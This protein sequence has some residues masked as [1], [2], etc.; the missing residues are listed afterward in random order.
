MYE[1]EGEEG[2]RKGRKEKEEEKKRMEEEEQEEKSVA[3]PY[4]LYRVVTRKFSLG[5]FSIIKTTYN[6]NFFTVKITDKV[7]SLSKF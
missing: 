6:V 2:E 3:A 4:I 5:I 1:W 7:L